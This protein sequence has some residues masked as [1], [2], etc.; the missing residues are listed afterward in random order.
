M[1][2]NLR[3]HTK[4]NK[5]SP[6][7][8]YVLVHISFD[9]HTHRHFYE[10]IPNQTNV[11][12]SCNLY[13]YILA[14]TV[15]LTYTS[16]FVLCFKFTCTCTY[17]FCFPFIIFAELEDNHCRVAGNWTAPWCYVINKNGEVTPGYCQIQPCAGKL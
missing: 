1:K 7:L 13:L 9:S 15:I 5:C 11:L 6:K 4:P 3:D 10:T 16:V 17:L 8:Q 2:V 12:Q 14:L